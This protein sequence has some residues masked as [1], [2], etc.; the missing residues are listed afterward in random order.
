MVTN[1]ISAFC[2]HRFFPHEVHCNVDW[3]DIY[4][5]LNIFGMET[6]TSSVFLFLCVFIMLRD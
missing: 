6:V 1:Q 2:L 4:L 5:A 3:E